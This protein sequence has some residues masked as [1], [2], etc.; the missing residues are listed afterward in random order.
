LAWEWDK[1]SL[2][3]DTP[4]TVTFEVQPVNPGHWTLEASLELTDTRNQQLTFPAPAQAI[5]VTDEV[6]NPTP[7]PPPTLPPPP[8]PTATASPSPSATPTATRTPRPIYLPVAVNESCAQQWVHADVVLV[9]DTSTSMNRATRSGRSKLAA[10][11]DA[12]KTFV[13]L[14]D[15]SPNAL[16]QHDQLAVVGFNQDAWI[17]QPLANE[18]ATI[19]RAIDELPRRQAEGTRLDL[20]FTVAATALQ[21]PRRLPG[22]TAVLILLTDG[23]PNQVPTPV[24]GG[25]Q[26]DT[27][28]AAAQLAKDAGIRSYTIAIG[29]PEDTNAD[30]LRACASDPSMYRYTPD[31][32]DL[33]TIYTEIAYAVGCPKER[34]WGG[35]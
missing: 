23:L 28:L 2:Q 24:G 13:G 27:V 8:T 35:R 29:A 4:Y 31:A 33:G 20:A 6:C 5:T 34:F 22:N 15:F 17:A 26:E 10:T 7:T 32:E 30:L 16:G 14:M 21:S 11:Q 9:L 19:G 12:A 1:T 18:A 25:S 3:L